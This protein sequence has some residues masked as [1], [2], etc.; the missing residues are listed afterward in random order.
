MVVADPGAELLE[1]VRAGGDPA[2]S[3]VSPEVL[4]RAH[5]V[6][7]RFGLALPAP[8][9]QPG[10][11]DPVRPATSVD[12]AAIAAV[13]WRAFGTSYRGGV[14]PDSFLDRRDVVPSAG[15]WTGRAMVP[16]TRRHRLLVLGRP[17]TVFGYVDAGP[18]ER[19]EGGHDP[20]IGEIYELYVDPIL[21]GRG[22]GSRLLAAAEAWLT[23]TGLD[24][25]ELSVLVTNPRAQAFYRAR[26]WEPTGEVRHVD[27]GVVAF[28]EARYRRRDRSS[29]P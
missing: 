8:F 19:G 16:P 15:F 28:D 4:A 24:R 18:A 13:K 3:T 20:D 17:G 1:L 10:D 26:G 6:R 5:L 21:Q 23:D 11:D 27:L 14:L 29:R 7:R 25:I 2:P 9:A 12:G 22:S